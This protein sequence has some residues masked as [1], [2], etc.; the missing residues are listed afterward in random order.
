MSTHAEITQLKNTPTYSCI[1]VLLW[2]DTNKVGVRHVLRWVGVPRFA[3][4]R[5]PDG[6]RV[7][8]LISTG[9]HGYVV[10][11]NWSCACVYSIRALKCA[12]SSALYNTGKENVC[13]RVRVRIPYILVS[14]DVRVH[15]RI[16]VCMYVC[17]CTCKYP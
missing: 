15:A 5:Q 9:V 16:H 13:A 10:G 17:I 11:N 6:R 2:Q 12:W 7:H 3:G 1:L 8:G 4:R 14:A